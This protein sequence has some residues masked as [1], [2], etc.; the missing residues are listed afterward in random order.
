MS[1][2]FVPPSPVKKEAKLG[3]DL[4]HHYGRGGTRVGLA[5]AHQ[6]AKGEAVSLQTVK[7]MNSFFSRHQKNK[8]TRTKSGEPGNGK[9][10]WLL[11][12]GD[13]GRAWS[14]DVLRWAKKEGL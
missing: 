10:A 3:L 14:K 6:L 4:R 13:A 2:S 8:N 11:W 5:R 7:R 1:F 12:G 9:I